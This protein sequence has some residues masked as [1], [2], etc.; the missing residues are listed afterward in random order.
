MKRA[1]ARGR[2]FALAAALT[3]LATL[4]YG[5]TAM[6]PSSA[7]QALV[8]TMTAAFQRGDIDAVM[9]A[10]EDGAQVLFDPAT[11]V[12]GNA[13]LRAAFTDMAS[14]NPVFT[15]SGHEVIEAGD[16]ALHIAPWTMAA[17]L[18]DD[19]AVEQRGLSLA[20]LRRQ[21]DGTWKMVIDNPHGARLLP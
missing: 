12:E 3:T 5:D 4:A 13:A 19:T 6:T 10:Y 18:P 16:I 11:P 7:P 9:Q 15:Y 1:F 14:L 8:E 17:T 2:S 20:V 21:A